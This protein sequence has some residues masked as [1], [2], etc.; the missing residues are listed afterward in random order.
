[1]VN[2]DKKAI[3]I[4]KNGAKTELNSKIQAEIRQAFSVFFSKML[5]MEKEAFEVESKPFFG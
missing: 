4:Q 1:M 5:M 3:S 2:F